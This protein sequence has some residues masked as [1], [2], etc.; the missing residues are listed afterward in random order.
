[1]ATQLNLPAGAN[2]RDRLSHLA[3]V[4]LAVALLGTSAVALAAAV[5]PT[6]HSR[7]L[8]W[9]TGRSLGIASYGA[10]AGLVALGLVARHP[11]RHRLGLH[12]ESLLRAHAVLGTT[13]LALVVAHV[14]ALA[15]DRYAG[16]GWLGA[17]VPGLSHYRTGAVALGVVALALLLAITATARLA[18][19]LG[20]R[21]WRSF[22]HLAGPLFVLVWLHGVLAGTDTAALRALYVASAAV[23]AALAASRLVARLPEP[24]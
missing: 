12:P 4:L 15:G 5:T 3:A 14:I 11:W 20:A 13:T 21:H 10:L 7:Y 9:I 23:L 16:V 2:G 8:P 1:M 24:T 22:H 17:V 18:G 19:R 6:L